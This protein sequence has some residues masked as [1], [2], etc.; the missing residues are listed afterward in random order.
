M[1][2]PF[3]LVALSCLVFTF[4]AQVNFDDNFINKTMRF[5]YYIAGNAYEQHVFFEQIREEPF[6]GGPTKNL[7]D[8]FDFGDYRYLVFDASTEKL[9]FSRGYSDLFFE[10]QDTKEAK[11]ISRSYY[12]SVVFPYPKNHVR[13][14]ID[15][16]LPSMQWEKIFEYEI[17]PA[18]YFIN[19]D[20][21]PGFKIDKL[22]DSGSSAEKVD[23]V[24]L[25]DAYTKRQMRKFRKDCKRFINYF[26][27]CSTFGNYRE[28]FNFWVVYAPSRDGGPDIPGKD[29]WNRTV[30]N[31]HFYTFDSERYLTTRDVRQIRDLAACVPYDQIYILVNS[32]KYG[33]GGI[34]NFYNLCSSDHPASNMVFTHEFGHA[35]AAL[36]DEYAYENTPAEEL[37]DLSV[38]PFQVNITTLADF[39]SKWKHLVDS[40]VPV[41]TPNENR[42]A[43][44]IGAFE[45]GGYV[46]KKIYRPMA[47]CKMR[48]NQND[49][50]CPVCEKAIVDMIRFYCDE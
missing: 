44:K 13:L 12:S 22:Y 47:D 39:D 32:E 45:G 30:L 8:R 43:A 24:I 48:S 27:E 11:E 29:I 5:D 4:Y 31:T 21:K 28:K 10:W 41:P 2:A 40:G 33:G 9:I 1:K 26:F 6:W 16:R 42:Y 36:A 34:Y 19:T 20:L 25:P 14:Q 50:F 23:I 46:K 18:S 15:R 7:I 17:D 49:R 35:F 3:L 38:E 37:Y